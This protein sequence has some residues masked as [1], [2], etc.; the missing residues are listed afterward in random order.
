MVANYHINNNNNNNDDDDN[1]SNS[2]DNLS[3][4]AQEH[5]C[6]VFCRSII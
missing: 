6:S 4:L 3:G 2:H 1:K 5:H